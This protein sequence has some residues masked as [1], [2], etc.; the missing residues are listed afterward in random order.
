MP[1]AGIM[2]CG[3]HEPWLQPRSHSA[4]GHPLPPLREGLRAVQHRQDPGCAPT[5][6][7]E[8][9][10]GMRREEAGKHRGHRQVPSDAQDPRYMC[11]GMH[12]LPGHGHGAPPV[13]VS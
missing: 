2:A 10:R 7:R 13:V 12:W 9:M 4:L 1:Q 6:P 5:P 11:Y 3:P 8:P